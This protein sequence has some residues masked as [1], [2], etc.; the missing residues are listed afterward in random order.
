MKPSLR[1]EVVMSLIEKSGS[2]K[3]D[4]SQKNRSEKQID[5]YKSKDTI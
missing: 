5:K 3:L 2:I 4:T 1:Q